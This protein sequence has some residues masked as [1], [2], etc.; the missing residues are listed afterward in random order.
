[1]RKVQYLT[2]EFGFLL[3]RY[4]D[5]VRHEDII[6]LVLTKQTKEK[7][8]KPQKLKTRC[9]INQKNNQ[10]R[11]LKFGL[12]HWFHLN[13]I[14]SINPVKY[15]YTLF[16]FIEFKNIMLFI[17]FLINCQFGLNIKITI[18]KLNGNVS[19]TNLFILYLNSIKHKN[20]NEN[21]KLLFRHLWVD[22]QLKCN[23]TRLV[24]IYDL[25]HTVEKLHLPIQHTKLPLHPLDPSTTTWAAN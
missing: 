21:K 13:Y 9:A 6:R 18:F 2:V 20:Q 12:E 1:M 22:Y 5:F 3:K 23:H 7:S 8:T 17:L 15:E 25:L 14:T 16:K 24:Y 4:N 19:E 10:P 11:T